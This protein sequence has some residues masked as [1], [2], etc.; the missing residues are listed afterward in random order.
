MRLNLPSQ[1]LDKLLFFLS[2]LPQA[3]CYSNRNQL[4]YGIYGSYG[5]Q[6]LI[7]LIDKFFMRNFGLTFKHIQ[8]VF[9][10]VEEV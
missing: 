2:S 7:T 1:E 4:I 9:E 5:I 10:M 6:F 8:S 3:F